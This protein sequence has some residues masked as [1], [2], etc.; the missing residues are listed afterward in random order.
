MT[1]RKFIVQTLLY[2]WR[3]NLAVLLGIA[4]ATAVIGGA[5]V[6]GDSV[7]ESLAQMT[8]DRLGRIDH[9]LHGPRFF[10]ESLADRL[11]GSPAADG[12]IESVAPAL[13][14]RAAL[15][16]EEPEDSTAVNR[17]G[18]VNLY[19]ID[20]RLWELTEHAETPPPSDSELILSKN[21]A[22]SLDVSVGDDVIAVLELPTA[23]PRDSLL[24][25]SDDD[26]REI[27]LTV[28][29]VL[30][31]DSGV[32][33]LGLQPSQQLP[34]NA[35]V[36]L[37]TLQAALD[38]DQRRRSS[39]FPNG[40]QARVN[41]IFVAGKSAVH[42]AGEEV[43]HLNDALRDVLTL[44]DLQLRI[45][46]NERPAYLSLESERMIL[47]NDVNETAAE[48][49]RS[50]TSASPALVYLINEF[51]SAKTDE[52]Y[53]MYSVIAGLDP[54]IFTDDA[55]SPF[56]PFQ[57]RGIAP[58]QPLGERDII[59]N[60]WLADDL[61]AEVGD[62]IT[63]KYFRAGSKGELGEESQTFIVR[64]IAELGE[65]PAA[66]RGLTP[67]VKGIT[68]VDTI[69]EWDQPFEMDLERL[70]ERDDDYWT[71]HRGTPKAFVAL[72]TAQDLWTSRYGDLT[73]FRFVPPAGQSLESA[74]AEWEQ[75]LPKSL[76][77]QQMGITFLPVKAL[78]LMAAGGT[79]DFAGLFI[80]FSFFII[81]SATILVGLLFR[82][83]I[84]QRAADV[85]LMLAVGFSPRRAR[86]LLLAEGVILM[87][88][89]G[90]L[91][92]VAAVGYAHLMIYGL[93]TWWVG[94]IG[95]RFLAVSISPL[96]LLLGFGISAAVAMIA[97]W[98][99]LRGL[100]SFP[101]RRLLAGGALSDT[102]SRSTR[103]RGKPYMLYGCAG[104]AL[105]LV[106]AVVSGLVPSN[107]A[108][109]GFSWTVVAFFLV[110]VLSLASSLMFLSAR[111]RRESRASAWG[112]GVVGIGRLSRQNAARNRSRSVLTAGLI[113]SATFVVAA[114]AAGHRNPAAE[115]PD[116]NSGNGGFTLVAESSQPILFDLNTEKGQLQF[117]LDDDKSQQTLQSVNTIAQFR[118]RPGEDASCLN[119]YQTR[120]PTILG[121]PHQIIHPPDGE[122]R[123]KFA[124]TPGENPWLL[125]EQEQE[126]GTIP[127]L[128][129]LN[130]LQ[131]S[132]HKGIGDTVETPD[133]GQLKIVGMFD[134]SVFQGQLLMSAANFERVF[135]NEKGGFQY[136][137]IDVAYDENKSVAKNREAAKQV[138]RLL[139][140]RIGRGFDSEFVA[141]RLAS[142]LAVQNTY[143]S[144]FLALG[145]L[146]LLLGTFG[147]ATVMLRNVFERRGELALMRAVGFRN[148]SL[149]QLVLLENG[150]LLLW[151]LAA[152]TLS[153][154]LAMLPHLLTT[155]ADVPWQM[156]AAILAGIFM[157]GMA[158]ALF[159]VSKAVHTPVLETLRGE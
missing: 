103:R 116:K 68:D 25:Q 76:P 80:G 8:L 148:L 95:T 7:R 82:L 115:R 119:I 150:L 23:V 113:A 102:V 110:G 112:R 65:A 131:Y 77:L 74:R 21:L 59:L 135:P 3:T 50:G 107:E 78:G 146:G 12:W 139:E 134:G 29:S 87:V 155:G 94:A 108:F 20:Q 49:G 153:A 54:K 149:T 13:V 15:E 10:E 31:G 30:S 141:D 99:S 55:K 67:Q 126:D 152:G 128:G 64:G 75:E 69:Q 19:G 105:I 151:G 47:E 66:D 97:V 109:G 142:F 22:D 120:L 52:T 70:T 83:G 2:H 136:F 14:M 106:L 18:K 36:A 98:W 143:L 159:A 72:K 45:R 32:A 123:F 39:S 42:Q 46:E 41:A 158:A 34:H 6:V 51:N 85:G 121:V 86:N 61:Q 92:I 156:G 35:F 28:K 88:V 71:K 84:E 37:E 118:M 56:G 26:V 90:L 91:G 62:E 53:S 96:S 147:L 16:T 93:K 124:N 144:T 9:V 127:V 138:R 129:D 104:T 140:S 48:L 17:A 157:A 133:G 117:D 111:L 43:E 40:R 73:S 122:R 137:L 60:T 5:L 1:L 33:R 79:T 114:V 58:E 81:L 89:G 100:T 4:A 125:L 57:F 130:T 154:L 24:G 145:G 63:L 101:A 38:I 11:A 44:A 27:P 132:L